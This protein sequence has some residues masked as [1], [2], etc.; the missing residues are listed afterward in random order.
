[1]LPISWDP[2][3]IVILWSEDWWD[4]ILSG[5]ATLDGRRIYFNCINEQESGSRTFAFY[6][7]PEQLWLKVEERHNDFQEYVGTHCDYVQGKRRN[8][9][10][11]NLH[12]QS[13]QQKFYDKWLNHKIKLDDSWRILIVESL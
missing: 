5:V 4:G 11:A 1:M 13:E 8:N 2:S 3:R 10:E 7:L 9:L 6:D 12:P